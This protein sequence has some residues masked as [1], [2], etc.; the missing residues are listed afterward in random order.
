MAHITLRAQTGASSE[1]DLVVTVQDRTY[2][3]LMNAISPEIRVSAYFEQDVSRVEAD[4][5]EIFVAEDCPYR[6]I[7][8][9]IIPGS[10]TRTGIELP[11]EML[12]GEQL[13]VIVE[14]SRKA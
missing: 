14:R 3:Y 12:A 1:K 4:Y 5:S 8:T 9:K 7:I 13:T 10:K 11:G 2:E 6:S